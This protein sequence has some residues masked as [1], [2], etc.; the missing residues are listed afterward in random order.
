MN[1]ISCKKTKKKCYKDKIILMNT[2]YKKEIVLINNLH[3][4]MDFL[5][6]G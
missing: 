1:K 3:V 2:S 4:K 6:H 5:Q